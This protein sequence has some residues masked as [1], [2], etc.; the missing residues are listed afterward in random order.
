MPCESTAKPPLGDESS[1]LF[2]CGFGIVSGRLCP[3][4][5]LGEAKAQEMLQLAQH[6]KK[7]EMLRYRSA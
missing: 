1:V 5:I 6:D 4:F 2:S 7:D 3:A